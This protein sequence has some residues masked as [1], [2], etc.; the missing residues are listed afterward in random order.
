MATHIEIAL[1]AWE[2]SMPFGYAAALIPIGIRKP[3][4]ASSIRGAS[5]SVLLVALEHL[6]RNQ[7][8][9]S[10]GLCVNVNRSLVILSRRMRVDTRT[11]KERNQEK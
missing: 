9:W 4:T 2:I 8:P 3:L 7:F 5:Y 11:R 6:P 10:P 1:L